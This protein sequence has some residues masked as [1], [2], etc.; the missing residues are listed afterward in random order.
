MC[1][2]TARAAQKRAQGKEA[3]RREQCLFLLLS[4]HLKRTVD[5]R[6]DTHKSHSGRGGVMRGCSSGKRLLPPLP[7]LH[8]GRR[9]GYNVELTRGHVG[10]AAAAC[11]GA[12]APEY[13]SYLLFFALHHTQIYAQTNRVRMNIP[14]PSPAVLENRGGRREYSYQLACT[15]TH[16]MMYDH[17]SS[18]RGL[19]A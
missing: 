1:R 14:S 5:R 10:G 8:P 16:S 4:Y 2:E 3:V 6:T 11:A 12:H 17:T 7:A 13:L 19:S 15:Q 18:H 9:G